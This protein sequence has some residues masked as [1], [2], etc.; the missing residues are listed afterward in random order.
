METE[1]E[2]NSKASNRQKTEYEGEFVET[3][4]TENKK[5]K[6]KVKGPQPLKYK[7]MSFQKYLKHQVIS[8]NPELTYMTYTR[9]IG[10]FI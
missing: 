9:M 8:S 1:E 4:T 2:D 10:R 5:A 6:I 7:S 3:I